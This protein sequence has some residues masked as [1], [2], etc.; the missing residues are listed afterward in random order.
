MPRKKMTPLQKLEALAARQAKKRASVSRRTVKP[1]KGTISSRGSNKPL[2]AWIES[3]IV[4][5]S[6]VAEPGPVKLWP[7]QRG[8]ADAI[9]DPTVER[10]TLMKA[11]RLGFSSLLTSA[12]G[13]YCVEQPSSV[14]YLLPTEADCRGFI[15]DDVEPL[16]D[17]SPILQGR[18][19]P[20]ALAR[21]DRNTM[22]HRLWP[23]GSLKCVAGKA[24][25][26]L[27][28]H[29]A[30]ILMIDE[31]DA[32][33]VSA[34]GDPVGLAERRTLTFPDRKIIV[35]GTPIDEATSHVLRSYLESD[36]RVFEVPCPSCGGYTEILWRHI[37]WQ[38][39]RPETA[40]FRCPHCKN[41][42]GEQHKPAMVRQGRWNA[43]APGVMGHAGFKLNA[44][45]SLLA[46]CAWGK[47]AAEFLL[48][49][50]DSD[51]L[52][53]FTN[54]LLG[55][56]WRD[57]A[58][59]VVEADL[60][61]RVEPFSLEHVPPQVLAITCGVDVG[62]DRIEASIIGHARDGT[63]FVLGHQTI[64][65]VPEDDDT[66][67]ELDALLKMTYRHPHGGTLKIDLTVVDA[68]Y[69]FDRVVAFCSARAAMRVLPG[70]GAAGFARPAIQLTKTKKGRRL[71][72]I[73]VDGLKSQI[74]NRLARGTTIRFSNTL[75][76]TYFEQLASEKKV[77]RYSRGRPT[78][79]FERK[80]GV[81]AESLDCLVYALAA[82]AALTLNFDARVVAV[83]TASE[84]HVAQTP[85]VIKSQWMSRL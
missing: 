67:A 36:Q 53:V 62:E 8:L 6:T 3:H 39:D 44:L 51:R 16:F 23:G 32:I 60:I 37:E 40:A 41:L 7:W 66:F 18:L 78:A 73:G 59:E 29:T 83:Q 33:E 10:V 71:F 58:D 22:L 47:L 42:V 20:P 81:R 65:G 35:G 48:V 27:R 54:T 31:V 26:N 74:I 46:N 72:I 9:G 4:L 49:K 38:T 70:K 14:L 63:I 84:R 25:R 50:N 30:R 57:L 12:I 69:V 52:K 79:R 19:S 45:V 82:K 28:R 17:A 61:G 68:G 64:W 11:T 75:T 34:E 85:T 2:A 21:R 13:F 15:V 1:P 77:I 5:P 76:A 43:T 56:P 55:E 24:P 80:V